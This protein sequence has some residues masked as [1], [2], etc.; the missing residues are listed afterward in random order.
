M[1]GWDHQLNGHEFEEVPRDGEGQGNL[2]FCR[3]WCSKKSD[4]TE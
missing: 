4:T 3:P 2:V 1:A